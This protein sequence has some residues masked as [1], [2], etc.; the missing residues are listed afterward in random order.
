MS[1]DAAGLFGAA[2]GSPTMTAGSVAPQGRREKLYWYDSVASQML[3]PYGESAFTEQT[4]EAVWRAAA[5]GS[6]RV[7]FHTEL[8]AA[9][10]WRQGVGISRSAEALLAAIRTLETDNIKK[11]LKEEHLTAALE[12]AAGL[13][14]MLERLN[15]GK[16]S[17]GEAKQ[18]TLAQ[19]KKRRLEAES[20][21]MPVSKAD[22][23]AAAQAVH[24]W[25]QKE[26]SPLRAILAILAG[27]GTFFAGHVAD[28]ICRAAI[29]HKPLNEAAWAAAAVARSSSQKPTS[30]RAT[31]SDTRGLFDT[32]G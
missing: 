18:P 11:L 22:M 19:L 30:E 15:Q 32:E 7:A 16:G 4:N 25:F 20:D 6:K 8:A 17:Q 2:P 13:K 10:P 21:H 26:R 5:Q 3:N 14:P 31:A 24:K 23:E 1:S 9:D 29:Q 12:E 27:N 28:K